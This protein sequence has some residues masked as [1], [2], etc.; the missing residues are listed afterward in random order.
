MR[1]AN[2]AILIFLTLLSSNLFG[3]IEVTVAKYQQVTGLKNPVIVGSAIFVESLETVSSKPVA[4]I[5]AKS[6]SG[7][8]IRVEASDQQRQSIQLEKLEGGF[9]LLAPGKT[10]IEVKEYV[11]FEI[12]GVKRKLLSDSKTITIELGPPPAPPPPPVPNDEFGNIG[13]RVAKWTAGLPKRKELATVYKSAAVKLRT[14]L[15]TTVNTVASD[16]VAQRSSVLGSEYPKFADFIAGLNTD[17]K[18]RPAM[19][20]G[21]LADYFTAISLGLEAQ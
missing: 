4:L 10:W 12:G 8:E 19:T 11:E 2:S 9:L 3:Q 15:A 21:V 18:S 14:D 16:V 17:F 1:S 20:K 6:E 13:Q 7:S 5:V